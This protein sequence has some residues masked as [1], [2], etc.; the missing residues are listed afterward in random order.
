MR[1]KLPPLPFIIPTYWIVYRDVDSLDPISPDQ[2][3]SIVAFDHLFVARLRI[4]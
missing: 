2:V 3:D 1:N 4:R